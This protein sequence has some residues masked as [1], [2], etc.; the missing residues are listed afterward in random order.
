[1]LVIDTKSVLKDR[2]PFS[3]RGAG[4]LGFSMLGFD[5]TYALD[6]TMEL[7]L[8]VVDEFCNKHKDKNILI[9][10]FTFMI[11]EYFYKKLIKLGQHLP[12]EK[13]IMIHGGG[14]KKMSDEAIDNQSLKI[15][16]KVFVGLRKY[17]I[18]MVWWSKL[19]Q[20]LWNV[21]LEI[22]TVRFF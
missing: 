7:D 10:G 6:E 11:W 18:T 22:F 15:L 20:F 14:W 5:V 3:A 9:F 8:D 12:L 21:R 2:N 1:M 16:L 19:G 13:G 17:I 4:I